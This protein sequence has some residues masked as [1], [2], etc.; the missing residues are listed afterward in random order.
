MYVT[1]IIISSLYTTHI[2]SMQFDKISVHLIHKMKRDI[3]VNMVLLQAIQ[4]LQVA[5]RNY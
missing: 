4:V 2:S 1:I 5:L 3:N